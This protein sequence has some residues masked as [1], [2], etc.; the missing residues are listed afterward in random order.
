MDPGSVSI[1]GILNDSEC[2]VKVY[3]DSDFLHA[4][5]VAFHPNRNTA[6][7]VLLKKDFRRFLD[8]FKEQITA[9]DV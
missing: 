6:T 4:E 7:L 3:L 2:K 5:K 8:L 1:F 9:F